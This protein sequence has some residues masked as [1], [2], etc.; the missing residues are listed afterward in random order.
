MNRMIVNSRVGA[1]GV[2]NVSVP[3]GPNEANREVQVTIEPA[4]LANMTQ[5]EWRKW[6]EATA[7]CVPD[8]SF[9]RHDQGEYEEREALA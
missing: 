3:V 8:P 1:D 6:V 2:L 7:G 9:R 4:P 5:D